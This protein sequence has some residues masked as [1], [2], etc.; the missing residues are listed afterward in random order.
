M[1]CAVRISACMYI[2]IVEVTSKVFSGK[3]LLIACMGDL[4]SPYKSEGILTFYLKQWYN[5]VERVY[6]FLYT[7]FDPIIP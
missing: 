6:T 7:T 2:C 3:G 1:K 5:S 4:V